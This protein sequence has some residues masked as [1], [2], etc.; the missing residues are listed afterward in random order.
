MF[1]WTQES[2]SKLH[3]LRADGLSMVKAAKIIGCSESTVFNA[4][5]PER[6]PKP[7]PK[8]EQKSK[9]KFISLLPPHE[10]HGSCPIH[11]ALNSATLKMPQLTKAQMYYDLRVAVIRTAKM[12]H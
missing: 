11:R 1:I 2:L 3:T 10:F 9:T 6:K 7:K 12:A 4:L 8:P 5:H